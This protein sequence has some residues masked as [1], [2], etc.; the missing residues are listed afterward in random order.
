MPAHIPR[1]AARA[2]AA[3]LIFGVIFLFLGGRLA[4]LQL[5]Q[6]PALAAAARAQQDRQLQLL[7]TR[8][9][10]VDRSGDVLAMDQMA[11]SLY[12]LPPEVTDPP[13]EAAAVAQVTGLAVAPIARALASKAA[14]VWVA[15]RLP[16]SQYRALLAKNLPGL[17]FQQEAQ[18]VY[19][20]GQ[21]AASVIGFVGSDGQGL[22][23]V[24]YAFNRQLTGTP[25][26]VT[27]ALDAY[28]NPLPE[29][30]LRYAPPENGL[31]VE[32]T[33]DSQLQYLAETLLAAT[34]AKYQARYGIAL[35]LDTRTG[36]IL[37]MANVPSFNPND[38]QAV[39]P[40]V[41]RNPSVQSDVQPGSAFKPI[42]ASAAIDSGQ[43]SPNTRYADPSGHITIQGRTIYNW[44]FIGLGQ[45]TLTEAL[46]QSDNVVFSQVAMDLG[47][48][49]FYRYFDRFGFDAPTGVDLPGEAS[50]VA[51]PPTS[52]YPLELATMGFG[53]TL[54]VTPLQLLTAEAAIANGGVLMWPHVEKALLGSG[55][56]V[57]SAVRP[58]TVRRVISAATA[59]AV[60]RMMEAVVYQGLGAPAQVP[61]YLVAGKTGTAQIPS[62]TGGYIPNSY[63]VS[64]IGFAPADNPQLAVLVM[65]SQPKGNDA[66]GSTIAGPV[67]ARLMAAGL[68]DLGIPPNQPIPAATPTATAGGGG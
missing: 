3:L 66:F 57:V 40:S 25:G 55:G 46:E 14:W 5:D 12:A 24:E 18:R 22:D 16:Q 17:Y 41:W 9:E 47:V 35:A 6:G 60:T 29:S 37:A 38:W 67:F 58:R 28:G 45:P 23:G 49:R 33:L 11:E 44:N 63:L 50:S 2:M 27:E 54:A 42:V 15:H 13:A 52:V 20:A 68:H 21:L 8:G 32:L 34:V 39:S 65:V 62:P 7:P 43:A 64:F 10:I 19:P 61:G 48:S 4:W 30:T 53:Q 26:S 56:R 51:P 1:R 59:R 36:E 31:T